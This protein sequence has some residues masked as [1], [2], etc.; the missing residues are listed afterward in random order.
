MI[1]LI[2]LLLMLQLSA[3]SLLAQNAVFTVDSTS[4]YLYP[5][6][7]VRFRKMSW[8][9]NGQKIACGMPDVEIVPDADQIDTIVFTINPEETYTLICNIQHPY[10][11]RFTYNE[12]C[13]GFYLNSVGKPGFNTAAV[14]FKV[15]DPGPELYEAE[16][17]DYS[18]QITGEQTDTLTFVWG[19]MDSK[20]GWVTLKKVIWPGSTYYH[21]PDQYAEICKF[22]YLPL[23][24][25]P[26]SVT[27]DPKNEKLV[28]K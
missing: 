17:T 23:G 27:Y 28:L 15:L 18:V 7:L 14:R 2:I 19:A 13:G 1:R 6:D 5:D 4:H 16:I 12:C 25:E 11:Y 24:E 26:F 9:I 21:T 3:A 10:T 20:V 22:L 8:V